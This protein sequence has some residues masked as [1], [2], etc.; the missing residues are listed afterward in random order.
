MAS[1]NSVCSQ[2]VYAYLAE[3]HNYFRKD[4]LSKSL[5]IGSLATGSLFGVGKVLNIDFS[6][7]VFLP[8][9]FITAFGMGEGLMLQNKNDLEHKEA[10]DFMCE[11]KEGEEDEG[12]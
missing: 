2:G 11:E 4:K 8:L 5:L 6:Y 3:Q 12:N 1:V 9:I 7:G 10:F